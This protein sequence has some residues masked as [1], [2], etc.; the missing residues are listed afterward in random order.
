[1]FKV[2]QARQLSRIPLK[3]TVCVLGPALFWKQGAQKDGAF[4]TLQPGSPWHV[5]RPSVPQFSHLYQLCFLRLM[6]WGQKVCLLLLECH[7]HPG[8][9]LCLFCSLQGPRHS[10][11]TEQVPREHL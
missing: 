1:M 10:A 9:E 11:G 7:P 3:V 4:S 8:G 5:G 2:T 6:F